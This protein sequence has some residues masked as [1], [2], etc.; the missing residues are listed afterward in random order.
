MA[1]TVDRAAK[2][3]RRTSAPDVIEIG[4]VNSMPDAALEATERQFIDLV[5]SAAGDLPV[6][7]RFFSLADVP[8]GERGR[9]HVE[10]SYG[11]IDEFNDRLDALIVTGTEPRAASLADEPYWPALA[12]LIDWADRNTISTVWSCLAAHAVVL[13]LDGIQRHPLAEKCIGVFDCAATGVHPLTRRLPSLAVPHSRHNELREAELVACGYEVLTRSPLAGVDAFIR[14]RNSL[15]VCFQ[16]HPEYDAVSLLGEYRRDIGRFLRGERD[17]YPAMPHGY[18]DPA[19]EAQ[20][21]AF[22]DRALADRREA[23]MAELPLA[24]AEQNLTGAWRPAA[25]QLYRNWLGWVAARKARRPASRTI[26]APP[27]RA[28]ANLTARLPVAGNGK[29]AARPPLVER[30]RFNDP[31]CYFTGARDRRV[32]AQS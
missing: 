23:L 14:Q 27:R 9:R 3:R 25:R 19:T 6:R 1:I 5:E 29:D 15:F 20:L 22:R 30:R 10:A 13:H 7:L 32:N 21:T 17:I 12:E 16:G 28:N 8:R 11:E 31:N 2:T 24:A 18:F 26:M 4:I